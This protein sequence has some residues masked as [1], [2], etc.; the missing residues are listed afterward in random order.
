MR[1]HTAETHRRYAAHWL[2][3]LALDPYTDLHL[4]ATGLDG[5]RFPRDFRLPLEH[6]DFEE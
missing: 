3:L 2:A 1:A 5:V 6:E 4:W